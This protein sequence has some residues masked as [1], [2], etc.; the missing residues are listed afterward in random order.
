V[1]FP[2]GLRR[3]LLRAYNGPERHPEFV[4]VHGRG[5]GGVGSGEPWADGS[6][7][8]KKRRDVRRAAIAEARRRASMGPPMRGLELIRDVGVDRVHNYRFRHTAISTLLRQRVDV[9]T[10]AELVG[11][12]PAMSYHTYGHLMSDHFARAAERL[13]EGS[14]K[15][16]RVR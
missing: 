7:F 10:I 6:A 3:S 8:S 16:P 11:T 13:A 4:F 1:F 12:S 14:R 2:P 9:P 15:D 5:R